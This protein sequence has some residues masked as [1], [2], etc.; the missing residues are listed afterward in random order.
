MRAHNCCVY[1]HHHL[2]ITKLMA[3]KIQKLKCFTASYLLKLMLCP[4][5][6][7]FRRGQKQVAMRW[8]QSVK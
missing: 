6:V 1:V 5:F 2:G 3:H 8:S 7:M 4:T